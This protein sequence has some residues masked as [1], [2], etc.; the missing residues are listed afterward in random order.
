MWELNKTFLNNYGY[1]KENAKF[2]EFNK[3]NGYE[4]EIWE[5]GGIKTQEHWLSSLVGV[6]HYI[7]LSLKALLLILEI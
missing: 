7:P 2:R 5:M 1:Y 6:I 3:L 4:D